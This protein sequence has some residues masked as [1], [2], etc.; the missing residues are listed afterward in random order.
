[1]SIQGLRD[2]DNF[3][4]DARPKNWRQGI[5]LLY[6]NGKAPLTG[7]TSVMSSRTVDDPE[8]NWWE[9][10][11]DDQKL[12]GDS[13]I[14]ASVTSISVSSGALTL[15]EGHLIWVKETDEIMLV[16]SDP[17]SDT[18]FSVVRGYSG[19]S[20]QSFD[21]TAS[22]TDPYY[23][24]IGNAQEE[25]SNAPTGINYDPNKQYNYTQIFRNTLEMTRTASKTRLRT[26]DQVKEAKREC[27][28]YH[29]IE[30]EKAFWFGKRFEGTRNG[31]PIRTL[32]G[33]FE[34]IDSGNIKD[35]AGAATDMEQLEEWLFEAFS[36]GSNEKVA[37]VGN[38]A[39]L[40]I[41]Q[42]VRKNTDLTIQ[43]GIREFGM[44]VTRLTCPFG[45]LV[46]KTH[47]LWNQYGGSSGNWQG[48]DSWMAIL[49]MNELK[50]VNLRDS[51]TKYQKVLQ[52][53]DLDGMKSGYLTECSLEMHHP[54]THYLI[55]GLTNPAVDS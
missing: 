46:M 45:E 49:D 14:S 43:S 36:F 55:K 52:T 40:T 34:W 21:P 29:S 3:V 10:A 7:L 20:G 30:M 1:M 19:T 15:K 17:S 5:L 8:F 51:D 18:S 4:A 42:I 32:G 48:V 26:G 11:L 2:T 24:V 47:P 25:G 33:V 39:L 13:S 27:L 54:K 44:N 50:Y 38:R 23:Y 28:E 53:N 16:D 37:M 12:E 35:Q 41:N 6:P 22:G 9:K 31:R